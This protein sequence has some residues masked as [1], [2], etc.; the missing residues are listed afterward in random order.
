LLISLASL[1]GL[2]LVCLHLVDPGLGLLVQ[3]RPGLAGV[4]PAALILLADSS[5]YH[6]FCLL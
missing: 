1:T 3:G 2:D 5:H 6:A 4:W